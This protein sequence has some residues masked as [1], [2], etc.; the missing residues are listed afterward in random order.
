MLIK[1]LEEV[2]I[3]KT[4]FY[5]MICCHLYGE[6][7]Q[8]SNGISKQVAQQILALGWFRSNWVMIFFSIIKGISLI[9]RY[10]MQ[11]Q[12]DPSQLIDGTLFYYFCWILCL[13]LCIYLFRIVL[14]YLYAVTIILN[15]IQY[16]ERWPLVFEICS[17]TTSTT[18]NFQ[19]FI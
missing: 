10:K 8:I 3:L 15:S 13:W 2:M 17:F 4:Q 12:H 5:S 1:L 18:C 11:D 16:V 9:Y 7:N 14:G 19:Y 6:R